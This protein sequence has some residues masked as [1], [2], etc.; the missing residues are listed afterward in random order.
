MSDLQTTFQRIKEAKKELQALKKAYK[1]ALN[2]SNV[3]TKTTEDLKV[4]KEKKSQLE[5]NTKEEFKKEFERIE[6]LQLDIQN[7]SQLLSD[8][9]LNDLIKGKKV[10]V[11]DEN[12][13]EYEPAFSV[14]FKRTK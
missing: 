10:E 2:N 1:D 5:N 11:R 3:Y 8:I 12:D 7:D 14:R 13:A 9:A 4:L 6:Q